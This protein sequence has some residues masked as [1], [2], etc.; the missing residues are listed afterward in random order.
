MRPPWKECCCIYP[1][2]RP[3][4][5]MRLR[6]ALIPCRNDKPHSQ[7]CTSPIEEQ[8]AAP[9]GV[10]PATCPLGG[11]VPDCRA[12]GYKQKSIPSHMPLRAGQ[13]SAPRPAAALLHPRSCVAI[14][15]KWAPLK[16]KQIYNHSP[17]KGLR[18][19]S[20]ETAATIFAISPNRAVPTTGPSQVDYRS[21][22]LNWVN[23]LKPCEVPLNQV[24]TCRGNLGAEF[25]VMT[26]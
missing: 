3:A 22:P 10:E 20:L 24:I 15:L 21:E 9:A 23:F 12:R 7:S 14:L 11:G 4:R 26:D 17:P 2:P 18:L 6:S 1:R 13:S 25:R 8:L 5:P 19:G 16:P